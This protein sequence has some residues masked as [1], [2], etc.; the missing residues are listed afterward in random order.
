MT[1]SAARQPISI[2]ATPEKVGTGFSSG[3]AANQAPMT[4]SAALPADH[5]GP[6][7]GVGR[8][9]FRHHRG[10]GN[11]QALHAVHLQ[12]GVD[13]T[14]AIIGSAHPASTDRMVQ[15]VGARAHQRLPVLVGDSI[16]R[17]QFLAANAVERAC[18]SNLAGPLHPGDHPAHVICVGQ[19]LRIDQGCGPGVCRGQLDH[20]ARMR[21]QQGHV[22]RHAV[23]GPHG[24]AVIDDNA[25]CKGELQVGRFEIGRRLEK[26]TG[27]CN[28]RGQPAC[29]I[30]APLHHGF[31]DHGGTGSGYAD[32]LR[33]AARGVHH[34]VVNV[35]LQVRAHTGQVVHDG[36]AVR[37]QFARR[38]NAGKHQQLRALEDT[39]THDHL[40]L[41]TGLTPF[42]F[43]EKAYTRGTACLGDDAACA[44]LGK[45]LEVWPVHDR[46]QERIGRRAT[47]ALSNGGQVKPAGFGVHLV[48]TVLHGQTMCAACIKEHAGRGKRVLLGGHAQAA[49]LQRIEGGAHILPAPALYAPAV[50]V[51]RAS[52]GI[53][54]GID[55]GRPSQALAAWLIALAAVQ[56]GL[57]LRLERPV[58]DRPGQHCGKACRRTNER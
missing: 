18:P 31:P 28:R 23:A 11:A 43:M 37:V 36:N 15:R 58:A 45:Y 44:G 4:R 22:D 47:L 40:T 54:H 57:A 30:L 25:R 16:G 20:P 7:V 46:P 55:R 14:H 12:T 41:C 56:T 32:R 42:T 34:H 48:E 52:T 26:G 24:L 2:Q 17:M 29:T 5:H 27:L 53:D 10:I 13:D 49:L 1:R 35:I 3:V 39:G 38:A 21:L 6:R 50:I 19:V 9:D 8:H 33:P 51:A